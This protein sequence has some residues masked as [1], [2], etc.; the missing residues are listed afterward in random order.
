[1]E[2]SETLIPYDTKTDW[3]KLEVDRMYDLMNQR[4]LP[5]VN[6]YCENC[7]YA[8]RRTEFEGE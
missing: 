6:P 2:F 1:M 4:E 8:A 5:S 3:I 7:A